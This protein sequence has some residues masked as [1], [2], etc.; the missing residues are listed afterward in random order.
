M[1][2]V[3]VLKNRKFLIG[4]I[5]TMAAQGA[6]MA[7]M[8]I[9]PIYVQSIMGQSAITA[10]LV[11]L[12]GSIIMGIMGPI[13][14]NLFDKHGPRALVITGL[15]ALTGGTVLMTPLTIETSMVYVTIIM[16]VRL[17]GMSMINMPA[18]TWGINALDNR[19]INHGNAVNNTLRQFAGSLCTAI[20]VS[21]YS[22]W[23]SLN[24]DALGSVN[25]QIAG[26][27][28]SFGLQAILLGL[29]LVIAI[30]FVRDRKEDA[31]E[32]DPTGERKRAI[33][34]IMEREFPTIPETAT[35]AD[36]A[37]IFAER[38]VDGIPVVDKG[39]H[40]VGFVSDGDLM[41]ALSPQR[42]NSVLDFYVIADG[43]RRIDSDT[44]RWI[45]QTMERPVTTVASM[46]LVGVDVHA[47]EAELYRVLSETSM[48]RVPVLDDGKLCGIINRSAM[49]VQAL[50]RY[51]KHLE[52][53]H[54]KDIVSP[55]K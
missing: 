20:V 9:M 23:T 5:V 12:P 53:M 25:A 45:E 6:T 10:A 11:M 35:V 55:T 46:R 41:R 13:A 2:H 26:T 54:E 28:F 8:V 30:F 24:V 29:A 40:P 3:E 49:T 17:F 18:S 52:H 48:R 36:A 21:A 7:N 1:L 44:E 34:E 16:A 39:G 19:L 38:N 37:R 15:I 43:G 14:G 47:S 33:E 32:A 31:A 27:N 42:E 50:D 22:L 4:T 51:L